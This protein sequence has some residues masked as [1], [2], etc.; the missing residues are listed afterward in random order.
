MVYSA[1]ATGTDDV[2]TWADC[3]RHIEVAGFAADALGCL[4]CS[5][6]D[7]DVLGS[8]P[9]NG[10]AWIVD[11]FAVIQEGWKASLVQ[12]EAIG[13]IIGDFVT[14]TVIADQQHVQLF[15][16]GAALLQRLQMVGLIRS[17]VVAR[18]TMI[19]A[20]RY[21]HTRGAKLPSGREDLPNIP[22]LDMDTY[23][24]VDSWYDFNAGISEYA[25]EFGFLWCGYQTGWP[26]GTLSCVRSD[27]ELEINRA[28]WSWASTM[29]P[30][31][32]CLVQL[33]DSSSADFELQ[34]SPS[35]VE[36]SCPKEPRAFMKH[37][38]GQQAPELLDC[39]ALPMSLIS[40]EQSVL[41]AEDVHWLWNRSLA[42]HKAG[43]ASMARYFAQCSGHQLSGVAVDSARVFHEEYL[44]DA[45]DLG[46]CYDIS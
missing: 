5:G 39:L 14:S 24:L 20:M 19:F 10:S 30:T 25:A 17:W 34:L 12:Q 11:Q 32:R 31:A 38:W 21:G 15:R 42:L 23:V 41:T 8:P 13:E 27:G 40:R 26:Q 1:Y 45:A 46:F 18:G 22:P 35:R 2:K 33:V 3:F 9:W 16:D 44:R 36:L 28:E 7:A 4:D 37:L 29:L 43:Y 6:V